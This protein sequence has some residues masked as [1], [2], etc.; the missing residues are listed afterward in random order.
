MYE[1]ENNTIV[2]ELFV[3][4]NFF[5]GLIAKK[6]EKKKKLNTSNETELHILT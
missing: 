4:G 1:Y 5:S 6:V 2:W 3:G